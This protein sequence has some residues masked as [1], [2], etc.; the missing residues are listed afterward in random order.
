[1]MTKT[2][3]ICYAVRG[4][5]VNAV[6]SGSTMTGLFMKAAMAATLHNEGLT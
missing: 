2:A 6:H 5:R 3:A 4:I 1:M